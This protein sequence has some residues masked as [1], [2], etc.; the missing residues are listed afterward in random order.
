MKPGVKKS[1]SLTFFHGNLNGIAAHDFAKIYLIQSYALSYNTGIIFLSETFLDSSIDA[2]DP[3]INISGHNSLRSDHPSNSKKGGMCMFYK[4]YLPVVRL[5]DLCALSE[6]I[7]S[8]IKFGKKS[9]FFTCNYRSPSHTPD[10]SE[11]Y[12]QNFHL[13]LSNIDETSPFCSIV[14]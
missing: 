5:D 12:C 7:V 11:N 1:S 4:D 3:N 10:E 13:T 9:I 8:E 14:I 2:S 6:C